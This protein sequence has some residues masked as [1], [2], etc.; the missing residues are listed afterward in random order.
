[1]VRAVVKGSEHMANKFRTDPASYVDPKLYLEHLADFVNP[2]LRL[3]FEGGFLQHGLTPNQL[4][5]KGYIIEWALPEA[6]ASLIASMIRPIHLSEHSFV[7]PQDAHLMSSMIELTD[8]MFSPEARNRWEV[9][10]AGQVYFGEKTI[11]PLNIM[12]KL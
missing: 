6:D 7:D 2:I 9:Q 12:T 1:M 8:F 5:E 4:K 3:V 10:R 11:K